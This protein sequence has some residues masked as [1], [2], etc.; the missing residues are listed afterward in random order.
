VEPAASCRAVYYLSPEQI[1][2]GAEIGCGMEYFY[3]DQMICT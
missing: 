1:A 2:E 3:V